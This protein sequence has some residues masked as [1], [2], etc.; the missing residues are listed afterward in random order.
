MKILCGICNREFEGEDWMVEN[1]EE[2]GGRSPWTWYQNKDI[3]CPDCLE[4]LDI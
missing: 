1:K 3:K 4:D 2:Q